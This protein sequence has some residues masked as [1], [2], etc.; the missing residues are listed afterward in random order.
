MRGDTLRQVATSS[1]VRSVS[2]TGG[3][4]S[5]ALDYRELLRDL[6]ASSRFTKADRPAWETRQ[7][8]YVFWVNS[9]PTVCLKVGIALRE[10][11][12]GRECSISGRLGNHFNSNT[13]NTVLAR[14]L[15]ADKGSP[16][17]SDFDFTKQDDRKRFLAERC[18]VQMIAVPGVARPELEAFEDFLEDELQPVYRGRISNR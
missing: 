10:L 15:E 2:I 18:V 4:V 1:I 6:L 8:V 13:R 7:G 11:K 9:E 14:H 3:A 17:A 12:N 5:A 16:W